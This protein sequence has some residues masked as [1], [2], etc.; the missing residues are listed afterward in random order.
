MATLEEVRQ[1]T[2]NQARSLQ[3]LQD[4]VAGFRN[5]GFTIPAGAQ[6]IDGQRDSLYRFIMAQPN[7]HAASP[8]TPPGMNPGLPQTQTTQQQGSPAPAPVDDHD[9]P[10]RKFNPWAIAGIAAGVIALLFG[11]YLLG[12]R[13]TKVVT[14]VPAAAPAPAPAAQQPIVVVAP[15][16]GGAPAGASAATAAGSPQV[17]SVVSAS[18]TPASAAVVTA[19]SASW[20]RA[21][22]SR[23]VAT[24]SPRKPTC[25]STPVRRAPSRCPL[26]VRRGSSTTRSARSPTAC[27]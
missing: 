16:S 7:L 23:W 13:D 24:G 1:W 9:E 11:A 22:S 8:W 4:A 20:G 5:L 14:G 19:P 27:P 15:P 17:Q 12:N 25:G 2:N 3:E 10:R 18:G 26:R 6:T 21:T